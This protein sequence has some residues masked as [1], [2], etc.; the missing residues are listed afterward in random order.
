ML[1]ISSPALPLIH[2]FIPD[3]AKRR[4]G[5]HLRAPALY[6]GFRIGA[7]SPLV[8]DDGA[9]FRN[10]MAGDGPLSC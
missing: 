7:A 4:S 6:D 5:I 9:F 8:R 3:A 1:A 10:A 2:T